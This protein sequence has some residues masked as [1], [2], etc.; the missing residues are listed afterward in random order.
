MAWR[1]RVDIPHKAIAA[2]LRQVGWEV[3]DVH[4]CRA[5]C[6]LVAW[7]KDDGSSVRL[8]EVKTV[9]TTSTG[10]TVA[11]DSQKALAKRGCPIITLTSVEQAAQLR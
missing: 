6:D 2:A 8:I 11:T 9:K 1:R 4:T 5:F 10:R 7:R 3:A